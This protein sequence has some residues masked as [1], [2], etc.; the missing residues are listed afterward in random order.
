MHAT[1]EST[2]ARYRIGDIVLDPASRRVTRAGK[3]LKLGG[4]TFDLLRALAEAAPGLVRYEDLAERVWQGR[5]VSPETITQRAKMLRDALSD[6]ARAPRYFKPVRG[7]GYRL[8]A[9]VE[10]LEPAQSTTGRPIG[11]VALLAVLAV[12]VVIA[13]VLGLGMQRTAKTASVASR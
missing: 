5:A 12:T 10:R 9:D 8:I 1:P 2:P 3:P 11:R 7:K 13:A 4:L 6:D